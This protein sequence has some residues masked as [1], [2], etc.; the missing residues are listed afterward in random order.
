MHTPT[1]RTA[2]HTWVDAAGSGRRAAIIAGLPIPPPLLAATSA[3]RRLRGPYTAAGTIIRAIAA[4]AVQRFPALVAA[5]EIELL[6]VAPELRDL[7]PATHETLTSLAVPEERTRFYSRLRTLRI[8]HGL[9]EFLRDYATAIGEP[10]SLVVD[11]VDSADQTDTELVSVLLRRLDPALLTLVV[12]TSDAAGQLGPAAE[13]IADPL[14]V[15][16]ARYARRYDAGAPV[17]PPA[18]IDPGDDLRQL[19]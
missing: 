18:A 8:A 11:E 17:S 12:G 13:R 2:Q 10:R 19:A 7:I 5:H 3:P 4:D 16:L 14:S 1:N 6:C 9:T 15:A